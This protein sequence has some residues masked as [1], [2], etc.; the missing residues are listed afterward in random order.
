MKTLTPIEHL[1]FM[2]TT[3]KP[4]ALL[5]GHFINI[6]AEHEIEMSSEEIDRI[7]LKLKQDGYIIIPT[8]GNYMITIDGYLFEENGGY[9]AK[10]LADAADA[11]EQRLEIARLRSV[12]V[13][14][15]R[16]QK[17]LN[18]LTNRL[19]WATWFA[20]GVALALLIWSIYSYRHPT[21]I[22]VNVKIKIE[23]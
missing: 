8:V 23:K 12:D 20:F 21:P 13:S 3:L 11:E 6:Y 19:S 18:R 5:I 22:P 17:T 2:L 14:N 10:V 7:A 1:D 16:N 4:K 9:H 15:D